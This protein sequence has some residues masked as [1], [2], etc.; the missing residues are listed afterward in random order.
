M[1]GACSLTSLLFT[2]F[3]FSTWR[4]NLM[5]LPPHVSIYLLFFSAII[6]CNLLFAFHIRK[7]RSYAEKIYLLLDYLQSLHSTYVSFNLVIVQ[8]G[9]WRGSVDASHATEFQFH[10]NHPSLPLLG[11]MPASLSMR[12]TRPWMWTFKEEGASVSVARWSTGLQHLELPSNW[13][14]HICLLIFFLSFFY[15]PTSTGHILTHAQITLSCML[16]LTLLI[17]MVT[18]PHLIQ[19]AQ[20]GHLMRVLRKTWLST[21]LS[22]CVAVYIET[23]RARKREVG[24]LLCTGPYSFTTIGV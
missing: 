19:M 21:F 5:S 9:H 18:R 2:S 16:L 11:R 20:R 7:N 17:S 4:G 1:C 14:L 8:Y 15:S 13:P 22:L 23:A 10:R 6:S 12:V 24:K 3:L